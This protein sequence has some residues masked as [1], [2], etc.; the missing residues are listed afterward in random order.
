[1]AEKLGTFITDT[2]M[3]AIL[4]PGVR[5]IKT[6]RI[7]TDS[8]SQQ[9][10]ARVKKNIKDFSALLVQKTSFPIET[11]KKAEEYINSHAEVMMKRYKNWTKLRLALHLLA[12]LDN[13]LNPGLSP[14][15][16]KMIKEFF[17][18]SH[19]K[20][21]TFMSMKYKQREQRRGL[22]ECRVKELEP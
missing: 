3:R 5:T 9:R 7:L 15:E 20:E 12:C 10:L 21:F 18:Y 6:L 1:M 14:K 8:N 16:F 4:S 11:I 22:I 2:D 19:S 13:L 17:G